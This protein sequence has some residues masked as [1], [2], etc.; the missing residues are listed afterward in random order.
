MYQV[1]NEVTLGVTEEEI[2]SQ[3][4]GIV[5]KICDIEDDQRDQLKNG[6]TALDL[7]DE[8]LRSYGI[9]TN[10]AKLTTDELTRFIASVKFGACL[11]YINLKDVTELDELLIKMRPSNVNAA[12]E[13]EL[14]PIERDVYRAQYTA[15]YLKKIIG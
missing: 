13:R 15:K 3:V 1:S 10:C 11:G 5:K 2:L 9:L 12:A 7:E 4:D 14:S 6:A 8:C